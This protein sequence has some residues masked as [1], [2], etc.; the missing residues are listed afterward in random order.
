VTVRDGLILERLELPQAEGL[1]VPVA[2][3]RPASS[4]TQARPAV[5]L[6]L[7]SGQLPGDAAAVSIA[8]TLARDGCVVCVPQHMTVA[9]EGRPRLGVSFYGAADTVGI[10]P[11]ALR[12]W[13]DLAALEYLPQ[14]AD[15]DKRQIAVVGLGVGGVDAAITIA[16]DRRV[17]ACGVVGA[18]TIR[19]W[20]AEVAPKADPFD[21][22]M[23]Y[24]PDLAL[25]T[26][27]QY[28]YA[29][30]AP[31]PLLLVD[32][33]DRANWPEAAYQRVRKTAEHVYALEGSPKALSA[34]AAKSLL[35]IEELRSWLDATLRRD[36]LR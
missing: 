19:D 1:R 32:V 16:L 15:V 22:I 7:D 26:D 27:W 30:A 18:I 31:R 23:P 29:A 9:Q 28:V 12:V 36:D 14:R 10:P 20:A 8:G 6:S 35:G 3:F 17:A 5:L 11:L 13:D 2:V 33:T 34:A 25:R 24:L 21:R 4:S